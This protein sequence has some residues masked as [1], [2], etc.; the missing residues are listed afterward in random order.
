[1]TDIAT[2]MGFELSD[3]KKELL[4]QDGHILALGGPGSGKT[5]IA[6]LKSQKIAE[7]NI[8]PYQRVLFLSFAR[9]T[10]TRVEEQAKGM[11][12]TDVRKQLEINTYHGFTWNLLKSH[13]YLLN[14]NAKISLLPPPE[15]AAR[16]ATFVTDDLREAEKQRL[17]D[18]EGLLHFDLFA[19]LATELLDGSGKIASIIAQTYP[20]IILDEFQDT[21]EHEWNFIQQLG[22]KSTLIA[23]ADSDQRIYEFRGADP[24]RI[25]QYITSYD[26]ANY[27]FGAENHRS[28]GTDIVDFGN[29]LLTGANIG[30]SYN[31]VS[32]IPYR[33][34]K[35]VAYLGLKVAVIKARA[36]LLE[37][38]DWS[39]AILV[40][41]KE[42]MTSVSDFLGAQ[43]K[44]QKRTLPVVEHDVLLEMAGPSLAAILIARMLGKETYPH[45]LETNFLNDLNEHIRGR[46]GG[47]KQPTKVQL[48]ISD[49]MRTFLETGVLRVKKKE[50][51]L[52]TSEAKRIVD[53]CSAL[54]F[55]GN[56]GDDWISIRKLLLNSIC[57]QIKQVGEDARYLRLLRKGAVLNSGLSELWRTSGSYFGASNLI[58]NALVQE[59]FS[60]TNTKWKGI[61]IMTMHA[62]KG[63]EFDEVII[64]EGPVRYRGKILRQ[65]A[66]E[67]SINQSRLAL[68]VAVTRAMKHATILTPSW[69]K[70]SLL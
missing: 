1:M 51:G 17:F 70:C 66:D 18:E 4:K 31:D 63:K 62:A 26:P 60:T 47:N 58:S 24:A 39:M 6:L 37:N 40:P 5:T 57:P 59:H 46:N 11:I 43:Q 20:V 22:K 14:N 44:I 36:R 7:T 53:E 34:Y 52:I 25:G 29:D 2:S 42:L 12:N 38:Q 56:P 27:D 8:K 30:K 68:R 67:K 65:N 41:T 69:D 9:A 23:L 13:G 49:S 16:L 21:N 32:C 45:D 10:I 54:E 3:L 19:R 48:A 28:N 64:Y 50:V 15:A 33:Y 55:S 35:D 61:H